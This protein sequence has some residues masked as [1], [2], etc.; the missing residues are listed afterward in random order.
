MDLA[1]VVLAAGAGVRLRPLTDLR[2][3]ALCPVGN[4]PLVEYALARAWAVTD[5]VAVNV[6]HH[7]AAM[8]EH[9]SGRVHLSIEEPSSLGTAGGLRALREWIGGRDV[10]VLNA[11][12]WHRA[13]LRPLLDRRDRVQL[14]VVPEMFRTDFGC[15]RFAGASYMPWDAVRGLPEDEPSVY[16][17]C[18]A[19]AYAAGELGLVV[20]DARFVDCG[21]PA[22]YLE[23][24]L[25]ASGGTSVIGY[26]A[27]VDGEVVRSV[28]WAGAVVERGERLEDA[29]RADGITV[30]VRG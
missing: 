14:Q 18:W 5:D 10:L 15:H 4:V 25:D 12:A 7:R 16:R 27:R 28:V 2:P 26:G 23:A 22:G 24:N 17:A 13:P 1:C 20:S 3:K 19:P 6:H 30:R 8:V 21:T 11:D 29:V 9:L